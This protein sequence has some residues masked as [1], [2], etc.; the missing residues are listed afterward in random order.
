MALPSRSTDSVADRHSR[1]PMRPSASTSRAWSAFDEVLDPADGAAAW[2]CWRPPC[3]ARASFVSRTACRCEERHVL[4]RAEPSRISAPRFCSVLA[5]AVERRGEVEIALHVAGEP[6]LQHSPAS[7]PARATC[8]SAAGSRRAAQPASAVEQRAQVGALGEE[9]GEQPVEVIGADAVGDVEQRRAEFRARH[10]TSPP[11][12][13]ALRA[14]CSRLSDSRSSSM[15]KCGTM[16]AS[17]GKSC[18]TRSQKAWMVWILRPPGVSS[19]RVKSWRARSSSV[20]SASGEPSLSQQLAQAPHR[21]ARSTCPAART[22]G[23]PFRR[24]PPW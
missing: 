23:S 24:R 8:G 22:G 15:V 1:S 2:S 18:S 14:A 11:P 6:G 19:A 10:R 3:A 16:P 5:A 4:A 21:R 13:R 20:A 17:T 9:L 12:A 7:G